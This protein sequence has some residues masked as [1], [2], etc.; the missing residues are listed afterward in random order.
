LPG[1]KPEK[2]LAIFSQ[3]WRELLPGT[4]LGNGY[5]FIQEFLNYRGTE[6][7]GSLSAKKH[8]T[9]Q[10]AFEEYWFRPFCHDKISLWNPRSS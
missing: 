4:L 8:L 10:K 7:D 5:F 2:F 3:N 1:L 9:V 6:S